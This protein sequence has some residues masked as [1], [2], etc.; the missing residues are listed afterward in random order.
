MFTNK[1]LINSCEYSN[2]CDF[3]YVVD[4]CLNYAVKYNRKLILNYSRCNSNNSNYSNYIATTHDLITDITDITNINDTSTRNIKYEETSL[5][6]DYENPVIILTGSI[7]I[8]SKSFSVWLSKSPIIFNYIKIQKDILSDYIDGLRVIGNLDYVSA[9]QNS[10]YDLITGKIQQSCANILIINSQ[11]HGNYQNKQKITKQIIKGNNNSFQE[12]IFFETYN[13]NNIRDSILNMLFV[14]SGSEIL[15]DKIIEG[16]GLSGL[17]RHLLNNKHLLLSMTNY[18]DLRY[19]K[20]P[21]PQNTLSA[22]KEYF[23]TKY[24]FEG[25]SRAQAIELLKTT[26]GI[27]DRFNVKYF[28][29]SGTLLGYVRHNDFI[30]WDDDMD[31]VVESKILNFL[32]HIYNLYKDR[33]HIVNKEHHMIKFCLH[34]GKQIDCNDYDHSLFMG[35]KGK[36]TWP[37]IDLFIFNYK[38][39]KKHK[40]THKAIQYINFFGRDFK[41]KHFFPPESINFLGID[42]VCIPKD[43]HY[44]LTKNYGKTY[45]TEYASSYYCHSKENNYNIHVKINAET[46]K[47]LEST[48]EHSRALQST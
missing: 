11:Q 25:N 32:P 8:D 28:L 9:P 19:T 22:I 42:N 27:L 41:S 10:L 35:G 36:Y 47:K 31:L 40:E 33:I 4:I 6:E 3:F 20:N 37:F 26:I 16:S 1:Y 13:E 29:I 46:F 38:D 23:S 17:S 45:M 18:L 30:P 39:L 5:Q 44:F 14:S 15:E 21:I 7:E 12:T 34:D 43:P 24:G 2:I 48:P